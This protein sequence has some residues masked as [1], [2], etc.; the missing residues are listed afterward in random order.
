ML[1]FGC[2]F[3]LG[4]LISSDL[5]EQPRRDHLKKVNKFRHEMDEGGALRPAPKF[6]LRQICFK[7]S[8]QIRSTYDISRL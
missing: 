7:R 5:F 1:A 8:D 2:G 6:C 3:R 4:T